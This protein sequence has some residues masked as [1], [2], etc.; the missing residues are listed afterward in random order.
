MYP[1]PFKYINELT[2]FIYSYPQL[3]KEQARTDC[4]AYQTASHLPKVEGES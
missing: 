2:T 4:R 3:H 1:A